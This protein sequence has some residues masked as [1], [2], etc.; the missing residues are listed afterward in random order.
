[1]PEVSS[2]PAT[3]HSIA[4]PLSVQEV[5]TYENLLVKGLISGSSVVHKFGAGIVDTLERSIRGAAAAS[6][7]TLPSTGFTVEAVSASANDT[8]AGSGART[9]VVIGLRASD[10]TETS[11]TITMNG[12]T[13]AAAASPVTWAR[14]YRAYVSGSGTYGQVD[15]ATAGTITIRTTGAGATH[16]TITTEGQTLI[17]DYTVP[18]GKVAHVH[19]I[20]FVSE[21]TRP[22]TFHLHAR[23][24]ADVVVAPF[25]AMRLRQEFAGVIGATTIKFDFPLTFAAKTDICYTAWLTTGSGDVSVSTVIELV[26][27]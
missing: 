17:A 3:A 6:T 11:E 21:S 20:T 25:P 23:E 1:M 12:T 26:D 13:P 19:Q 2:A 18:A 16:A 27:A 10:W 4:S 24:N 8:A 9:I 7:Y 22:C 15:N 5:Q 14:I